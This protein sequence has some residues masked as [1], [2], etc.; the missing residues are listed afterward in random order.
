MMARWQLAPTKLDKQV[1]RAVARHASPAVERPARLLT[2]AADEHVLLAISAALWLA[3]RNDD[4]R[5]RRQADHL[6][7]S[8][9]ATA[10]LPHLLKR[11]IDQGAAGSADD[12]W[13]PSWH[14]T[15]GQA[16]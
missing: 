1:A 7:L 14:S 9:G 8:V 6:L 13:P 3:S 10:I 16:L 11:V 12:P 5:A 4:D 15:L 2:W